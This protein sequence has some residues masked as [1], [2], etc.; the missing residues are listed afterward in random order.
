MLLAIFKPCLYFIF[1]AKALQF[2]SASQARIIT[3]TMPLITAVMAGY[4]LGE[5]ITKKLIIGSLISMIG[6]VWLS[7]NAI[8]TVQSPNP[9]LGNF[10]EFCAMICGAGYTIAARYLGN[11]FSAIFI[12][13]I[14]SFIGAIFFFPL[15]IYEYNTLDMIFSMD[16]I[17]WIFY[18]GIVVTLG[19]YGLYNFALTKIPASKAAIFINL[20]PIFTLLLAYLIL[21]ESLTLTQILASFII[22]LGVFISQFKININ[23]F[24]VN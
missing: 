5:I 14:Q 17:L 6:V 2:T 15:F 20:I 7:L 16:A 24:R 10:L 23:I 22:L 21:N 13:A 19:G 8:T 1:E 11:K 18:L 3:S 9:I 12:T 4:L